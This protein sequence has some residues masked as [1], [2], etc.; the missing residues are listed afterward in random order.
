MRSFVV[1]GI[2]VL[3]LGLGPAASLPAHADTLL[4]ERAQSESIPLPARGMT[5]SQVEARFGAPSEK[6]A[7]VGGQ[8]P[9]W[10]PITRWVYPQFSVYFEND[11][12][13]DAVVKQASPLEAGPKPVR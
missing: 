5:M 8:Q 1:C 10:P 3:A 9:Q 2:A 7:P 4:I 13:V 11:K 6:R 12:V